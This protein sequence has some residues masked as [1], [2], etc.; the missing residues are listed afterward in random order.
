[1]LLDIAKL[2][3]AENSAIHL[4]P[5]DDIAVARGP[6]PAGA[7]LR[8]DGGPTAPRAESRDKKP[9]ILYCGRRRRVKHA[10]DRPSRS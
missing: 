6:V 1:M 7:E 9:H 3:T 8:V 10:V 4:H 2:P 5:T